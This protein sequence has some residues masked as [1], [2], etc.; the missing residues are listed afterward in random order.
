MPLEMKE[1]DSS[2]IIRI[3]LDPDRGVARVEFKRK[4]GSVSAIWEYGTPEHA[5]TIAEFDMWLR[6]E[7]IGRFFGQYIKGVYPAT[8][9]EKR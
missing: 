8:C 3:G 4:D 7:S 1:V 5:I 2:Q 9:I 6:S